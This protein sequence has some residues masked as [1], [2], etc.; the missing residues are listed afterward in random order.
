MLR[1]MTKHSAVAIG[2]V[3]RRLRGAGTPSWRGLAFAMLLILGAC[4]I[5]PTPAQASPNLVQN[6]NFGTQT[7]P[8]AAD[9]VDGG[10]G[11]TFY[12]C[13]AAYLNAGGTLSQTIA[14][15]AGDQYSFF[16]SVFSSGGGCCAS[17]TPYDYGLS[18]TDVSSTIVLSSASGISASSDTIDFTATRSSTTITISAVVATNIGGNVNVQDLGPVPEPTSPALLAS[19]LIG[20][21]LRRRGTRRA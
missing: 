17:G 15:N 5:S 21:G 14:T 6:Y 2:L 16:A 12:C 8:T 1:R 20:L 18:A 9:W 3:T 10:T 19:G 13:F 11:G 7:P 4:L